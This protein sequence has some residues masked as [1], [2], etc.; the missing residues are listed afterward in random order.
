MKRRWASVGLLIALALVLNSPPVLAPTQGPNFTTT[1]GA[2]RQW[3]SDSR[4]LGAP[5]NSCASEGR[6]NESID[7]TGFGFTIP[8]AAIINGIIVEPKFA[9]SDVKPPTLTDA[10]AQLLK[11]GAP[12][13]TAKTFTAIA[14]QTSCA[15]SAF[16]TLGTAV[17]LWGTTWTPAEINAAML[18]VR[19]TTLSGAGTAFLDAVRITIDYSDVMTVTII[20]GGTLNGTVA[21]ADIEAG[22]IEFLSQTTLKVVSTKN[23]RVRATAS[24]VGFPGG[25]DDPTANAV[26]IKNNLG[27]FTPAG[28]PGVIVQT[29]TPTPAAGVKFNVDLRVILSLFGDGKIGSYQFT[30]NYTIEENI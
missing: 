23:W 18:G 8:A 30:V 4:A 25:A 13:G 22:R 12:V 16:R 7:L 21:K 19:I 2:L 14:G 3:S 10:K 6:A 28:P 24:V 1:L 20:T 26:E 29:G 11:A 17:D 15:T 9:G 27:V 5:D